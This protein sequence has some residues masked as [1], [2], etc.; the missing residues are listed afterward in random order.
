MATAALS[1]QVVPEDLDA[2]AQMALL[3]RILYRSEFDDGTRAGHISM[4]LDDG[5]FLITPHQYLWSE[6]RASYVAH[7][8]ATGQPID[9]CSDVAIVATSLHLTLHERRPDVRVAVHNHPPFA[10]VWAATGR[11]PPVYDQLGAFVRDD[12][13]LYD[14][15]KNNVATR[16]IA[17]ENVDAMGRSMM[18]LLANHGVFVLGT[19]IRDAHLRCIALEHRCRLAWRVEALGGGTPVRPEVNASLSG[20]LEDIGG[21][22]FLLEAAMRREITQDPTVLQ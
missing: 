8:D 6:M 10:T 13:V 22:P 3:H 20:L 1:T 15:F 7:I 16:D 14:D 9:G 17:A 12:L 2:R 4:R 18:A 5:T 21:W 11:I 19:G